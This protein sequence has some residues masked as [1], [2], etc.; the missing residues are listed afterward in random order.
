MDRTDIRLAH[1]LLTALAISLF[2]L[3]L[4]VHIVSYYEPAVPLEELYAVYHP[5]LY[6]QVGFFVLYVALELLHGV[7]Y[8][9]PMKLGRLA[10]IGAVSTWIYA[11]YCGGQGFGFVIH[12]VGGWFGSGVRH[13]A[14]KI[15]EERVVHFIWKSIGFWSVWHL[16]LSYFIAFLFTRSFLVAW[17]T[18]FFSDTTVSSSD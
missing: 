13:G 3:W 5:C 15:P 11:T 2:L 10:A 1:V 17:R 9:S 8:P 16:G 12:E 6:L 4:A 18:W 7:Y 14:H